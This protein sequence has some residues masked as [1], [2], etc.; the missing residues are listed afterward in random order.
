[1]AEEFVG[2]WFSSFSKAFIR[3]LK[4]D[5]RASLSRHCKHV[6]GKGKENVCELRCLRGRLG[7]RKSNGQAMGYEDK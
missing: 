3:T 6:G 5:K 7:G 4:R 2:L 1:M